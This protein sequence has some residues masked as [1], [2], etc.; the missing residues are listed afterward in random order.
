MRGGEM[1]EESRIKWKRKQGKIEKES[2][3]KW[4]RKAG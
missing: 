4:K 2:R 3:I 1:E